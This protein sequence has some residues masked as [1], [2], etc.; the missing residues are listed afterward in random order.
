MNKS[1]YTGGAPKKKN[2]FLRLVVFLLTLVLILGAVAAVAYRDKLNL[3]AVRRWLAYRSVQTSTAG[4]TEPFT[5]GGGDKL[6]IACL[7]RGYLL[8]SCAGAR[9]YSSSGV[10]LSNQVIQMGNPVLSAGNRSGVVYDAG[11]QSLYL[12]STSGDP[13]IYQCESILSARVN[14]GGMLAVTALKSHYRG[15]VTV[16]GAN[17]N[18]V[19]ALNYSSTFVTDAILSPDGKTVAVVT[20]GQSGGTFGSTLL[21][22]STNREESFASIDLGGLTVLDM[23]FDSAG[24]WLL[25]DTALVTLSADGEERH[26]YYYDPAYLKSYTLGGDGF[27]TLLLG[28]YRAGSARDV[29]TVGHDGQ[30]IARRSLNYQILSLSASGRYLALLSGHDLELCTSD[31]EHYNTLEDTRGARIACVRNDASALLADSQ[32]AWLYIPN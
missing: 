21:L 19:M 30:V 18:P 26:D 10:E 14:S 3:D 5:H 4:L 16:L 32:E 6:N 23:D 7:D 1:E 29:V 17:H 22:Y 13:F 15:S 9:C 12:F 28:K 11:G 24:L 25:C 2:M 20:I 27:A 8:A 31:L